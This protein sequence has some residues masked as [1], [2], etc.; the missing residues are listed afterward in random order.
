MRKI[1]FTHT[2]AIVFYNN[3]VSYI[4]FFFKWF[5]FHTYG[6]LSAFRRI[7]H[8]I[9][10]DIDKNLPDGQNM[11]G[12]PQLVYFALQSDVLSWPT[13]PTTDTE[14]I[15]MEKMG[16][17]VG[18]IKM[19][20]GKKMNSFYITDDEGKLDFEGVGEKD[21]KSFIM[22]LRIYNP[23]L[24]SKLL[25]FINLAKNENLVFIAPDNNGNNFLLGDALRGA[26]LD[27]IDGMTTGQKTEERPGAGMIFSYKTANICQYTGTIPSAVVTEPG[28]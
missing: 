25:G 15:T 16:A 4:I 6:D 9:S 5:F 18:D 8:R 21:G 1:F 23:G 17:L 3:P 28:A 2:D 20:V 27:S 24:Q 10:D 14:N 19:K 11:G 12:I 26:I 7:L 22:K 13:P